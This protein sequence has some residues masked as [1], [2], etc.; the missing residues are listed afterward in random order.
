VPWIRRFLSTLQEVILLAALLL[1]AAPVQ[2]QTSSKDWPR[3]RHADPVDRLPVNVS[4][5]VIRVLVDEDFAPFSFVRNDGAQAGVSVE[6][7][8]AACKELVL[9]C[10]IVAKPFADLLPTLLRGDGEVLATGYR[11]TEGVAAQTAAT[12]PYH[13]SSG[14]FLVR[15]GTPLE[16]AD[17]K[18]LAGRRLGYAKN[19]SHGAF[20]EHYYARS[21]LVPFDTE[22]QLFDALRGGAVDAA[23]ADGLHVAFWLQGSASAKCCQPLGLAYMDR[24][25]FSRGLS[26][27]LPKSRRDL[28]Q[29]FDLA[30]D[31]LEEKGT[32]GEIFNRYM[33]ASAW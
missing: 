1:L 18:T 21:A 22:K 2:A 19:T 14:R 25:Y 20:V 7:A 26:F 16:S 28:Q 9:R 4:G 3:L 30:L 27:L 15:T 8:L 31:R 23:F 24:H 33:P 17:I 32:T 10:E 11:M 5:Q 6:L 12:R 13:M 29:A